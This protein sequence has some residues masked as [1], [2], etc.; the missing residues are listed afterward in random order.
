MNDRTRRRLRRLIPRL[1]RS[2]PGE[3]IA[4]VDAIR[5]TL[6]AADLDLHD[7]ARLATAVPAPEAI[8]SPAPD[9]VWATTVTRLLKEHQGCCLTEWERRFLLNLS[10]YHAKSPS[11]A[12]L[13]IVASIG[14]KVDLAHMEAA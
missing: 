8:G 4:T 5:R 7:L 11:D 12:Q 3:V 14:N 13:A 6:A 9:R 2:H 1:G 10:G